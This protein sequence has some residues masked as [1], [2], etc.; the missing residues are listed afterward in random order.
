MGLRN[1]ARIVVKVQSKKY[2]KRNSD[3]KP[4]KNEVIEERR[5]PAG[6]VGLLYLVSLSLKGHP[7]YVDSKTST[8]AAGPLKNWC[9]LYESSSTKFRRTTHPISSFTSLLVHVW[10]TFTE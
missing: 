8:S 2:V 3:G 7:L 10:T 9:N 5:I 6:C 4:G 1:P